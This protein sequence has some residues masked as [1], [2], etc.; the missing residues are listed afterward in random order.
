MAGLTIRYFALVNDLTDCAIASIYCDES[1]V[2]PAE[3][4]AVVP[5][6]RRDR[7]RAEFAFEFLAFARFLGLVTGGAELEVHDAVAAAVAESAAS[8]TLVFSISSGLLPREIDPLLSC[9][10]EEV[11]A[12]L[13]EWLVG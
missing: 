11:A 3:V 12:T 13:H 1:K 4:V 8:T 5:A 7:L 10:V 6:C 9:C 2:G